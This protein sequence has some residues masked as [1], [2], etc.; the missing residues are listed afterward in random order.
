M[1]TTTPETVQRAAEQPAL[2]MYALGYFLSLCL[3]VIAYVMV[4]HNTVSEGVL[5]AW[6][7]VFTAVQCLVQL[8]FFLHL[9][10]ESKPRWKLLVFSFMLLVVG[11]I[12]IGSLWIMHNL[13]YHM[14]PQQMDQ[15]MRSQDSL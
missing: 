8:F 13:D 2:A 4:T 3:T 11:I 5:M 9:G 14:T 6:V 12:V 1:K 10:R 15:Y 7:G